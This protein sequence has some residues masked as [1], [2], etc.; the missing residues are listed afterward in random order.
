MVGATWAQL[1]MEMGGSESQTWRLDRISFI[2]LV[3]SGLRVKD[4]DPDRLKRKK[5]RKGRK[6]RRK[7]SWQMLFWHSTSRPVV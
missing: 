2:V 5:L 1:Y 3:Q 6:R 7:Q 4:W